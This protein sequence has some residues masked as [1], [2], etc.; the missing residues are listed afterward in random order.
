MTLFQIDPEL[1]K[2]SLKIFDFD[3]SSL[4]LK[5]DSENPWF[6]L[7]PRKNMAFELIDLTVEEQHQLMKEIS[8]VS[9]FLKTNFQPTKINIGALG[10]IVRQLHIHI[11]ARFEG[12]RAWPQALWGTSPKIFFS[13]QECE[14]IKSNFLKFLN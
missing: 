11:I 5:N 3:L 7:V 10:N 9:T 13:K 4:Y 6:V 2:D 1:E 8:K 14:Q 12:D